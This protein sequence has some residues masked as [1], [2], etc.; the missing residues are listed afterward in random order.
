MVTHP[1]RQ[2]DYLY[3]GMTRFWSIVLSA[4]MLLQG[5]H[6]AWPDLAQLDEL[7]EHA[8]YHKETFGDNFITF[9]SKHYGEQKEDHSQQHQEEREQ[10]EQL[11][12]QQVAH[13]S[14]APVFLVRSNTIPLDGPAEP[15]ASQAPNFRYLPSASSGYLP[16]IFQPPRHV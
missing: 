1:I 13:L 11:P 3:P 6:L 7:L 15:E 9:L 12:F 5:M 14:Y 8:Q 2:F 16:G 4:S 10:H